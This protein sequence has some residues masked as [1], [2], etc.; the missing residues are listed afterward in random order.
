M[1]V[2]PVLLLLALD[3]HPVAGDRVLGKDLAAA[4]EKFAGIAPDAVI[5]A[6]PMPGARRVLSALELSSIARS[7]R[8]DGDGFEPICVERETA[9]LDPVKVAEAMRKTLAMPALEVQ[10]VELSR[11]AA[12]VGARFGRGYL[13]QHD[14]HRMIEQSGRLFDR[15]RAASA[16]G[17]HQACAGLRAGASIV[18]D[19]H[20]VAGKAQLHRLRRRARHRALRAD[21]HLRLGEHRGPDLLQ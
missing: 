13:E 10:I 17:L 3:C 4:S 14:V 7:H 8:I 15:D 1:N 11:S 5:A 9:P 20:H 2:I 6:A 21:A 12:A 16:A 18:V 19:D